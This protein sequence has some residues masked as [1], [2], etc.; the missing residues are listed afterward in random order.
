MESKEKCELI[1]ARINGKFMH[2]LSG[3]TCKWLFLYTTG[4][5]YTNLVTLDFHF[6]LLK[7]AY[8]TSSLIIFVAVNKSQCTEP[9]MIKFADGNANKKKNHP[10]MIARAFPNEQGIYQFEGYSS[11]ARH[12]SFQPQRY[13]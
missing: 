6:K 7:I 3:C 1:I 11:G 5:F 4:V 10:R 9:L 13:N 8:S 12:M 2:E